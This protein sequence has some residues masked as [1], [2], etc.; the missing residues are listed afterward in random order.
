MVARLV[1][2][3]HQVVLLARTLDKVSQ[4]GLTQVVEGDITDPESY[5]G[6]LADC[7]ACVHLVGVLREFKDQGVTFDKLNY[8]ATLD[9]VKACAKHEVKRFLL[10]SAN[11]AE[12]ALGSQFLLSK[13]KEEEAVRA[14]DLDWTIFRPSLVYGGGE[15]RPSFLSTLQAAMEHTPIFP[16]FG[17][18]DY[19][20]SPVSAEEVAEAV[21]AALRTPESIHHCYHLCGPE[22]LEY[23]ELLAKVGEQFDKRKTLF[24]LPF[25]TIKAASS[26]LG[27]YAW[28][29]VTSEMLALLKSE[30]VCPPGAL[31]HRDLGV[32]LRSFE[33]Y[34]QTQAGNL[35]ESRV[36]TAL[37]EG[38]AKI[39]AYLEAGEAPP[40]LGVAHDLVMLPQGLE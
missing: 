34:L 33:A 26:V 24:P 23:K 10:M 4:G 3:E 31:T 37:T 28:F 9:L 35:P 16:Y 2:A 29:P 12:K 5:R 40:K 1:Q 6:A 14:T 30:N 17:K 36:T 18:G 38:E 8:R 39:T 13:A 27:S 25:W 20:L 19:R 7:Q 11:G 32:R 22:T 15:D 21:E